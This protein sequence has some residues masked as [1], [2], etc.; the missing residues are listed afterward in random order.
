MMEMERITSLE[1]KGEGSGFN[2]G[3]VKRS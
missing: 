3:K 2:G 1:D